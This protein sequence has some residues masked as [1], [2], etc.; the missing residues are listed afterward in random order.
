MKRQ[1]LPASTDAIRVAFAK[2]A[3]A[4]LIMD[5]SG[6]CVEASDWAVKMLG[7]SKMALVGKSIDRL[8]S[9]AQNDTSSFV[10]ELV[11]NGNHSE[12]LT[13][14][15]RGNSKISFL[16]NGK[17]IGD[18]SFLVTLYDL[19]GQSSMSSKLWRV[20]KSTMVLPEFFPLSESEEETDYRSLFQHLPYGI[21]LL[22]NN[23]IVIANP[24][25]CKM[26]GYR[27]S[28]EVVGKQIQNLLEEGS[29]M[30]FS[31]LQQRV[32]RGETIP[33]R[34]ETRMLREDRSTI[35]VETTFA[36]SW[37]QGAPALNVC[38]NDITDRKELEK[39][40]T[41]SEGLLRNVIDSMVD[42]L[43]ITDLQGKVL[44]VNNEFERLTGYSRRE[45]FRTEIPYPWVPEEDLRSY[46]GWLEKLRENN[47]LRDFDI[48]W[49]R[50][51]GEHIAVSLNTTLLRN[52]SGD[53]VL[54]VNIAR[55]ISER[56]ASQRE[57]SRQLQRLQVLY[58]LSRALTETF[59][60]KEIARITFHQVEKVIPVDAFFINLYDEEKN[61]IREVFHV[62][63]VNGVRT[64]TQTA[65]APMALDEKMAN[66]KVIYAHKPLLE[67]RDTEP[68]KPLYLPFGNEEKAAAS[69]MYVPMFSKDRT[70]GVLSAQSYQLKAYS[71][72]QLA[73]L[74]SIANVTG[75]AIE[76][77]NLY[78]ETISNSL[79]I[80]A[81]NKELDDFTYVVSH[82]LKEPLISV[83]G[84]A[85][86]IKQEY[87]SLFNDAGKEYIQSITDSCVHMKRLIDELL[88][89]SRVSKL[90]EKR[91]RVDLPKL[92]SEVLEE[93]Q[94]SIREKKAEI[95]V[96]EKLPEVLGVDTHLRIVFRNLISNALKFS[97]KPI[98]RIHISAQ[99]E[100]DAVIISVRD[101]GIGIDP[102]YF[103]KI[104][105]IFQRLHKKE[106][107]EGAG[108]GLTIVKKIIEA[109][110]GRIWVESK[111]HEGT[112]F[113]FTIA[114][115]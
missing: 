54:M 42:A 16:V 53:P 20:D 5:R 38:I 83:E 72:D 82:D 79:E 52:S 93:Q 39:R 106:E 105:M 95:I 81:R 115:S 104:F 33:S 21:C 12:E 60:I 85:K 27:A 70:I 55:D 28:D 3:A 58:D 80:E 109:N 61:L 7:L 84:Y 91:S 110:G 86:I 102:A 25:F 108:A 67:L 48:T 4:M 114:R 32:L 103:D 96:Q 49:L 15:R 62:D 9:S 34:F 29:R 41:D 71:E 14:A 78:Q 74:Q 1:K 37:Y 13:Y 57:L 97:D 11:K 45:A 19:T 64:E 92:I 66:S 30:F 63:I 46:I 22:Q 40:L 50:K 59:D 77:A 98:P 47:V 112:V 68:K 87:Y 44:D 17:K 6:H 24:I 31:V 56:Q 107:Y 94:F 8:F 18:N 73:L 88:Q 100:H 35:D 2:A 99:V 69:L 113:Y 26:L 89:L 51:N 90:A 101:N 43:I 23:S 111:L 75:I 10:A 36:L 65:S 76:K